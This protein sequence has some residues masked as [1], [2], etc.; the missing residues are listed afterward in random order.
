MKHLVRGTAGLVAAIGVLAGCADD[1]A[2]DLA[3]A[4][5]RVLVN[6]SFLF[7]P[8]GDSQAVLVRTINDLNN[9]VLAKYEITNVGAGVSVGF[10]AAYRPDYINPGD[11]LAVPELKYQQRYFVKALAPMATS[12]QVR[13]GPLTSTVTVAVV[14]DSLQL[15]TGLDKTTAALGE[16]VTVT[17]PATLRFND[18]STVTFDV[19]GAA[20][21]TNRAADGSSITF[22]P[23]PGTTG[24]ARVSNVTMRYAPAVA[25][26]TLRTTNAVTV[27]AVTSIPA[28]FAAS[29]ALAP[30]TM[31]AA[32]FKF[33]PSVTVTFGTRRAWV[34]SVAADSLSAQV[35]LP[36]GVTATAPTLSNA[37]LAFLPAVALANL[38]GTTPVTTAAT[39]SWNGANP[40]ASA[41]TIT[42]AAAGTTVDFYDTGDINY[43]P[44]LL[45]NGGPN[46][47]YKVVL[48]SAGSR[49]YTVGWT[50]T[51]DLD[52]YL[53]DEAITT[54]YVARAS[55]ANP[56][57]GSADRPAGTY[58]LG[59]SNF[60]NAM[61]PGIVRIRI[62]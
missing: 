33:L 18:N 26:Q 22:L 10:D 25:G 24:P 57:T 32:G 54:A 59:T 43:G 9:A 60:D 28:T 3:G 37:V 44:D 21:V 23:R 36:T 53:T 30:V 19:G 8:Q 46:K 50:S 4:P 7:V 31:T 35:V 48:P 49:T 52:F 38:P 47:W 40:D 51:A 17:A 58:W 55:T 56:E 39:T 41:P 61:Y 29:T 62:R 16:E 12:F 20:V 1:P 34:V 11:T 27:P 5:T 15:G 6:P 45:E 42:A 14:P 13:N 2:L